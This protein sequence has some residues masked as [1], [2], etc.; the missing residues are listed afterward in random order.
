MTNTAE[1]TP[2]GRLAGPQAQAE[3]AKFELARYDQ[4]PAGDRR[5][6]AGAI[7]WLQTRFAQ[8]GSLQIDVSHWVKA[9]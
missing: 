4:L 9:S 1:V 6:G 8:H 3:P 7:P 2:P 5:E